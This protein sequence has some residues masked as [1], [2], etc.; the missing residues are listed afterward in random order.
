[1][2]ASTE[3]LT[4]FAVGLMTIAVASASEDRDADLRRLGWR[5]MLILCGAVALVLG[6]GVLVE[7]LFGGEIAQVV[8]LLW[9][10][11]VLIIALIFVPLLLLL[12]TLLE[13]LIDF[14]YLNQLLRQWA[15]QLQQQQNQQ[16]PSAVGETLALF[17]PWLEAVLR[18]FIALLPILL[19]LGLLLLVRRRRRATDEERE[20][21]LSWGSL[22]DDLRGLLAHM[23]KPRRD[24]GLRAALARLRGGD[25][26]HRIRRSYI[27]L[28][29]LGEARGQP[30]AAPQTPHEYTSAASAMLPSAAQPLDTLTGAYE[31][32]RYF[33]A[34]ATDA[35]AEAAERAWAAI[36][37]A[38][39]REQ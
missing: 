29:L 2:A 33:P 20:S 17:P 28:L 22:A 25:P 8:S 7:S 31:R 13:R 15:Q 36:E 18:I 14:A 26:I 32:A 5:G 23:R 37:Q 11:V 38:N 4:F 12:V 27:R 24:G 35:D 10:G 21:L 16:R 19:I 34:G 39:R 6:L 3:V 30:R 1:V 9:Q